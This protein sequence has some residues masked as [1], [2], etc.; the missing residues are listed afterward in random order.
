MVVRGCLLVEWVLVEVCVKVARL[1]SEEAIHD[2]NLVVVVSWP[3][4]PMEMIRK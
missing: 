1:T 2:K 3:G 4:E